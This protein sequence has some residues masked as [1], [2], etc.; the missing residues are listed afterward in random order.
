MIGPDAPLG[1][2]FAAR[3]PRMIGIVDANAVLSSVDNDCRHG[4]TSR[5]RLMAGR[6]A[7][8]FAAAHVYT[9]VY[10]KL[11]QFAARPGAPTLEAL[12]ACFEQEYLPIIRFVHVTNDGDIDPDIAAITD[13]DDKPTRLIARASCSPRTATSAERATPPPTGARLP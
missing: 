2:A 3:R 12:R 11:P 10:E 4:R 13:P 8:L 1:S 5:L 6:S 9:E 7:A